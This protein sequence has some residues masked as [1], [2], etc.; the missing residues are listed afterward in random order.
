MIFFMLEI[1]LSFIQFIMKKCFSDFVGWLSFFNL[2]KYFLI[3]ESCV[4]G[5]ILEIMDGVFFDWYEFYVG[6][7]QDEIYKV[8]IRIILEINFSLNISGKLEIY[9]M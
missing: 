4:E 2:Y 6:G 1:W 8:R 9:V 5:L 3:I 7:K